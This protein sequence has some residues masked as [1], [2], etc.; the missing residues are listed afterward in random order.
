MEL[1]NR[2]LKFIKDALGYGVMWSENEAETAEFGMLKVKVEAEILKREERARKQ[3][4]H[5][6]MGC[7][8]MYCA[9]TPKCVGQC[10]HRV[11]E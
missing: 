11:I 9:Q 4:E 10:I 8:F 3:A 7:V 1:S 2:E 5:D 6:K